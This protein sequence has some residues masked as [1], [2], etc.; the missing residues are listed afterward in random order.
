MHRGLPLALTSL[1]VAVYCVA[2]VRDS[3]YYDLL[4]VSQDADEPTIKKAYRRQAM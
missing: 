4:G 2:A 1:L 3:K